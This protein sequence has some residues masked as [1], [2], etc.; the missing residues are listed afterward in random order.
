MK[1]PS[2]DARAYACPREWCN[3][4]EVPF[5]QQWCHYPADGVCAHKG[6]KQYCFR[7]NCWAKWDADQR[8]AEVP[9]TKHELRMMWQGGEPSLEY[10]GSDGGWDDLYNVATCGFIF[11]DG[12]LR[13]MPYDLWDAAMNTPTRV[14]EIRRIEW[15][16]HVLLP[17]EGG[18]EK[19]N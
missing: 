13:D 9:F 12:S 17:R 2:E 16:T 18:N 4:N 7:V 11:A 3:H 8:K 6:C 15:A 5:R 10:Q 14:E 19:A 1:Q